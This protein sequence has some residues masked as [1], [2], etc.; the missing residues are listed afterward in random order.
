MNGS[1]TSAIAPASRNRPVHAARR[2][3]C[4]E[5]AAELLS[6]SL[7]SAD[8]GERIARVDRVIDLLQDALREAELA[9]RGDG[10]SDIERDFT[11]FLQII[12]ANV[13][14]AEAFLN[15]QSHLESDDQ[16]FLT[17]FLGIAH[18]EVA[19]SAM[20]YQRMSSEVLMGLWQMLRLMHG[21]YHALK[22]RNHIEFDGD[23]R[24]RYQL[25]YEARR[26]E[27]SA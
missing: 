7:E 20:N 22:E 6:G 10:I 15:N 13:R 26:T 24:S 11:R 5:R 4:V 8:I 16:S 1:A 3:T 12:L 27:L 23:A 9:T 14:S 2:D 18:D 25:A 17:R 21:P 19:M